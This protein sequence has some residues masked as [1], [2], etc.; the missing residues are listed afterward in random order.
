MFGFSY[1]NLS[2]T[3]TFPAF[4]CY[5]NAESPSDSHLILKSL[6][7]SCL[8][9]HR[10][11]LSFPCCNHNFKL[12]GLLVKS[13]TNVHLSIHN[14]ANIKPYDVKDNMLFDHTKCTNTSM[15]VN[16]GCY[17]L[18]GELWL[19]TSAQIITIFQN[20]YWYGINI[21]STKICK[22]VATKSKHRS[23]IE[24]QVVWFSPRQA[25]SN[26]KRPK[27]QWD[28]F[29][30]KM[31]ESCT[32]MYLYGHWHRANYYLQLP[33]NLWYNTNQIPKLQCFSS[34][35]VVV[36]ARSIW[37]RSEVENEDVVGAAST[38]ASEW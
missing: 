32:D 15:A 36:F 14:D 12:R 28:V 18:L 5:W 35:L 31:I 24:I 2:T 30:P 20:N 6:A 16:A 25:V 38:G 23:V 10:I 34:C 7:K 13:R 19:R 3:E 11:Q 17:L 4:W 9:F 21:H 27:L 22:F 26:C 37:A 29:N 8:F 33:S 1:R